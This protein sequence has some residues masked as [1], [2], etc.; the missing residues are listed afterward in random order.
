MDLVVYNFNVVGR[1]MNTL[2]YFTFFIAILK[3]TKIYFIIF[4]LPI[5]LFLVLTLTL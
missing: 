3:T 4:S 1:P 2:V 5:L